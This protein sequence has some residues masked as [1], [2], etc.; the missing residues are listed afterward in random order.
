MRCLSKV[1]ECHSLLN[2]YKNVIKKHCYLIGLVLGSPVYQTGGLTNCAISNN[3]GSNAG[4][5]WASAASQLNLNNCSI[6]GN[7]A[8]SGQGGGIHCDG[9]T[10]TLVDSPIQN[11]KSYDKGGGLYL[12]NSSQATL[13]NCPISGNGSTN[14][15]NVAK[16]Y[17]GGVYC[18]TSILS[19]TDCPLKQNLQ[20][21]HRI[22]D[23][24]STSSV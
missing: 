17:G 9:S 2:Q 6:T 13:N 3:T 21:L 19:L 24:F 20:N 22:E 16:Y 11:N 8:T 12:V 5:V 10:L 1:N 15:T 23:L 14:N 18:D 4:G 7:Q